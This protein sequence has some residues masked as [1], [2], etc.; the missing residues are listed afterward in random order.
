MQNV[1]EQESSK[2]TKQNQIKLSVP[3]KAEYL[4]VV[5][6]TTSGIANRIG[7]DLDEIE[8]IKLAVA[9]ACTNA[10]THGKEEKGTYNIDFTIEKERLVI[11]VKDR[12]NGCRIENIKKPEK[13]KLEEGGLGLFI[14]KSLMDKVEISSNS[15]KGTSIKMM[16]RV[17]G[18]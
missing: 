5:R 10:M 18:K 7:F 8:D 12:G 14:I 9:E 17:G 3:N 13:G 1:K 2:K 4:S 11:E 15:G 16:K 6:L